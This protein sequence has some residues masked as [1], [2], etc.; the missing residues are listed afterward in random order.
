MEWFDENHPA[1]EL[2]FKCGD[3]VAMSSGDT[4]AASHAR[5]TCMMLEN[6]ATANTAR[7]RTAMLEASLPASSS[8][9]AKASGHPCDLDQVKLDNLGSSDVEC[10]NVDCVCFMQDWLVGTG[11]DVHVMTKSNWTEM[12]SPTLQPTTA[13]SVLRK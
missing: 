3:T 4:T 7:S 11:A 9:T 12:G 10:H 8:E 5:T 6:T 13:T 1:Q 2:T